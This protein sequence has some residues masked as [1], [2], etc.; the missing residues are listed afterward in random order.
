MRRLRPTTLLKMWILLMVSIAAGGVAH[1][2]SPA[3]KTVPFFDGRLGPLEKRLFADAADGRLDDFSLLEA[4]LVAGG[5]EDVDRLR[6]YRTR[7]DALADELRRSDDLAGSPRRRARV[8]LEFLHCRILHAGY[9]IDCTGTSE[10]L[11]RGRFNCVS[12]SVLFNCLAAEAG[13]RACGLEV[14]RHAMSRVL[15]PDGSLDVETTCAGWFRLAGQPQ[16]QIELLEK[17][18]GHDPGKHSSAARQISDVQMVALIYYN[19][20]VDLLGKKRFSQAAAAN[21]KAL[22][23]DPESTTARGNLLATMNNW[24]ISLGSSGSYAQAAEL[25]TQ[26]LALDPNYEAFRLNYMH[27]HHQWVE[28]LRS[29][30]LFEEALDV[31]ARAEAVDSRQ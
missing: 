1:A 18:I 27:V 24:A 25:L 15:L 20:G 21:A 23:L 17:R 8:V 19:R 14:P 13:L 10:A 2:L 31:L 5:L 29:A 30:G 16:R 7:F 4:A 6:R 28:H 3:G 11:D 22:T 12:A 26:G 9:S